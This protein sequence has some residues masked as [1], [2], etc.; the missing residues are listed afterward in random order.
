MTRKTIILL[1]AAVLSTGILAAQETEKPKGYLTGSFETNTIIYTKDSAV[2]GSAYPDDKIGSNNYL[3]LDY[4]YG[5][6]SA[7]IQLE[8][9]VPHVQDYPSNLK[10]A[11][12]TN[13]Y[14]TWQDEDFSL[15]AGT[16]YDQFGSG[17]LF[18][19]YEDRTIGLNNALMGARFTYNY[20]NIVGVKVIWG[21]PRLG[22]EFSET[23]VRGADV[24]FSISDLCGWGSTSLSLEGSVLNRYEEIS[25]DLEEEGGTP[26]TVGYS[27]RINFEHNAFYVKAEYVDAGKKYYTNPNV[28]TDGNIYLEKDGNAQL[29][30]L[31]YNKGSLGI[32]FTGRRLEWMDTK[33]SS[34]YSGVSNVINYVPALCTQHTYLLT[35]FHPYSPQTGKV[36]GKLNSGEMGGQLDVYYNFK[37]GTAIGGKRGLKLHANYATYYTIASEGSLKAGRK[38]YSDLTVDLEKQFTKKYKLILLWTMQ[39]E[40]PSYGDS[41][42]TRLQNV[43]VAD[44][45]YKFTPKFSTRLELQYLA[46]HEDEKDWMAALLEVNFAPSWSIWGSDMYNHGN[47]DDNKLHYYNA[48]V[49][50]TKS[51]TRVA[52]GFGRYKAGYLCS[53][54]VCRSI[55]AYRGVNFQITTSF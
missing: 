16:F 2:E 46:T 45:L 6:L 41:K 36:S 37:K 14:I 27:G 51:R 23:Q 33:I 40:S 54:G 18:R 24:H 7:G 49:S 50:Y 53:G 4:Y 3:K 55:T 42:A 32:S 5:K 31:G 47:P 1:A 48:G 12:M 34:D 29:V 8:A 25:I 17:L 20:R 9:Y 52:L 35:N 28:G 39:E 30:E 22:M 11:K 43:F 13:Y 26:S 15:T 38:L 21:M 19:S 10:G 44:M